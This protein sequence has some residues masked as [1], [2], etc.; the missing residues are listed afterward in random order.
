[1]IRAADLASHLRGAVAELRHVGTARDFATARAGSIVHPSAWIIVLGEN[2]QP[3]RYQTSALVD[4]RV[5]ARFGVILAARDIGDRT[6][7][8]AVGDI[9]EMRT[10]IIGAMASHVPTGCETAC[11]PVS[12]RLLSGIGR[13]G[14][15]FWQDDFQ[16]AFNRRVTSS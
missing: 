8:R 7:A 2:A 5:T 14:A 4:Q 16:T 12:G 11:T 13:D 9:E 6:G 10:R 15:M 3:N 1:M